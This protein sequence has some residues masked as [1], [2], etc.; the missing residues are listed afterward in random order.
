MVSI[1]TLQFDFLIMLGRLRFIVIF[2]IS[3]KLRKKGVLS[4][5]VQA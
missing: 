1:Q 2:K 5:Y 4:N 3:L